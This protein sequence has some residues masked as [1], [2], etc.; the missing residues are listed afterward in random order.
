MELFVVLLV[1]LA[2]LGL[3]YYAVH[4]AT[5]RHKQEARDFI[6][7]ME[8]VPAPV[9]HSITPEPSHIVHVKT[10]EPFVVMHTSHGKTRHRIHR[11]PRG[12]FYVDDM[13]MDV[14]VDLGDL[15]MMG[16][17]T[18]DD[19]QNYQ[20]AGLDASDAAEGLLGTDTSNPP[21]ALFPTG[22]ADDWTYPQ[23]SPVEVPDTKT[24]DWGDSHS[25]P[26][27]SHW[28]APEPAYSAPEPS[29]YES[30]SSYSSSDS[31]SS[32]SSSDSSS[33]SCGGGGDW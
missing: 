30:S 13:D 9:P 4:R 31:S 29:H 20:D 24:P 16:L 23:S 22:T 11:H 1:G 6:A 10:G 33:S 12:G 14:G 21:P 7:H 5:V 26:E 15:V 2:L 25:S 27:P 19:I 17:C 32:Y 3:A 18:L 8:R 28:S